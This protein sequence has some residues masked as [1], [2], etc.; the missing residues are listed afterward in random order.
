MSA[1][2]QTGCFQGQNLDL[3][4]LCPSLATMVPGAQ[5]VVLVHKWPILGTR[6]IFLIYRAGKDEDFMLLS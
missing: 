5:Q 3:L 2:F 4:A 1:F 6:F